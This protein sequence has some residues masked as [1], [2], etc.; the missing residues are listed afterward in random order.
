MKDNRM[1]GVGRSVDTLILY[2]KV[3]ALKNRGNNEGGS[4]LKGMVISRGVALTVRDAL[5]SAL[6][7]ALAEDPKVFLMGEEVGYYQGAYKIRY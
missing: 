3:C 6:E 5:N 4:L 2:R 1:K 7:E